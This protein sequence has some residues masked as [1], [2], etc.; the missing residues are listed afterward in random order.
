MTYAEQQGFDNSFT[1]ETNVIFF[2]LEY[3]EQKFFR[4]FVSLLCETHPVSSL[5]YIHDGLLVAP[6]PNDV[7]IQSVAQQASFSTNLPVFPLHIINLQHEWSALFHTFAKTND[8]GK[9]HLAN[10]RK[11]H[12][13]IR[14]TLKKP[15]RT[16]LPRKQDEDS[17]AFA[18]V[19][20]PNTILKYLKRKHGQ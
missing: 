12:V 3:I 5:V 7:L 10:K 6:P 11:V 18:L 13:E 1:K 8:T 14:T 15:R 19:D 2:A 4:K 17:V 9:T 20:R 16:C